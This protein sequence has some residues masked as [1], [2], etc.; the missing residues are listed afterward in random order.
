MATDVRD[1]VRWWFMDGEDMSE[2]TFPV[3][4]QGIRQHKLALEQLGCPREVP[5]AFI[6]DRSV[7]CLSYHNQTPETL[8]SR[9]GLSPEEMLAV[10]HGGTLTTQ[11]KLSYWGMTPEQ[12]VPLLREAIAAW[13][14]GQSK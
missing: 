6:A 13:T 7:Q 8:A 4:W 2:R 3:L 9:G 5:W 1:T 11:G 14:S 10:I 12:S